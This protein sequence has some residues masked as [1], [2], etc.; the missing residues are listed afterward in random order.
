MKVYSLVTKINT[1][2]D[3]FAG[4]LLWSCF[5]ISFGVGQRY[6]LPL[7]LFYFLSFTF[8]FAFPL[9]MLALFLTENTRIDP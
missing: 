2:I 3:D 7:F 6:F 9:G 5:S 4:A 8:I 1:Y